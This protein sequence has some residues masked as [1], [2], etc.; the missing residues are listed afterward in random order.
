MLHPPASN[1]RTKTSALTIPPIPPFKG[2][3]ARNDQPA[4]TAQAPKE[5]KTEQSKTS[6]PLIPM[7]IQEIPS[8]KGKSAQ[9]SPAPTPITARQTSTQSVSSAQ[10]AAN[11][12]N[13]NASSFRPNPKASTFTPVSKVMTVMEQLSD[14]LP[15]LQLDGGQSIWF[16]VSFQAKSSKRKSF[17]LEASSLRRR[18]LQTPSL[19]RGQ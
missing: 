16:A 4:G 10:A 19:I 7:K 5:A 9:P 18:S 8:F 3:K 13:V 12:L 11:R 6:K 1:A 17:P 15:G 2:P 14:T